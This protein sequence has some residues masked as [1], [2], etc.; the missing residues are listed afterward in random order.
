MAHT[1]TCTVHICES[2]HIMWEV[3]YRKIWDMDFAL[4][5]ESNYLCF[6]T[7]NDIVSKYYTVISGNKFYQTCHLITKITLCYEL[8]HELSMNSHNKSVK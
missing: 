8:H 4:G 5:L 7:Q 1:C 2:P 3:G 6:E